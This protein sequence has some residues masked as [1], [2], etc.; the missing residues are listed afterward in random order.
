MADISTE[1][2]VSAA[3][4][5][6]GDTVLQ[7]AL[8]S[9]QRRLGPGTAAAYRNLKEGP[10][11]GPSRHAESVIASGASSWFPGRRSFPAGRSRD[12]SRPPGRP[13]RARPRPARPRRRPSPTI[14][15]RITFQ[16]QS[17]F[18]YKHAVWLRYVQASIRNISTST[19]YPD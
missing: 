16:L 9:V 4:E 8:A 12:R 3:G 5:A 11:G 15:T 10:P 7:N 2:Y 17:S 1:K 19:V 18:E 13:R 6:I 14:C